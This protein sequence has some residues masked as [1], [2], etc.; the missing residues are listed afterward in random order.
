MEYIIG[1]DIGT[2]S[3]KAIAFDVAGKLLVE[4]QVGYPILTPQPD[5]CEQD[6]DV[7]FNA[8]LQGIRFITQKLNSKEYELLGV[9]FSS[10]MHSLIAMDKEGK[11]LTHSITWADTRSKN[12]AE[13]LRG[14]PLGHEI[15]MKTGTPIHPMSPLCK[16]AWLKKHQPDVFAGSERFISIKEYVLYRLFGQYVVDYSIASATGLFDIHRLDWCPQA[17]EVAGVTAKQL[18]A[19]VPPTHQ[20][21]GLPD[22]HAVVMGVDAQV[23]FIVGASDGCLANVGANAILPGNAAVTIGTSGAIRVMAQEPL[24]DSGERLF[25]YVLNSK[26]F[27]LGGAV[28]SGGIILRWFRDNFASQEMQQAMEQNADPYELLLK[29]AADIPA[30]A[31][32]LVF[33]PYLLG[34]R[35]PYWNAD[36]RGMFFGVDIRHTRNHFT[37]AV[38]EGIIYGL[39]SVG[40][41]LE[42]TAGPINVI[43]ANGGFA[44]SEQWVQML[45]DIFNKKVRVSESHETTA[46]GAAVVGLESLGILQSVEEVANFV[47]TIKEYIP[48]PEKQ[49]V[50]Q[51]RFATFE[52]LY[53]KLKDEF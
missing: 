17:L 21:K 27:I 20:L 47:P 34:E 32:G 12:I 36:A 40:K 9:S 30:G 49:A 29:K 5:F 14:T 28:N 25:S 23:P 33:L 16:L 4:N 19:L 24:S 13:A 48:D 37:R 38:M 45:A 50:Y 3:T 10:A 1:L 53:Q 51:Q 31:E 52:R 2:T 41:A 43:Y 11:A 35:A 15:Y 46:L 22:A 7:I 39:C 8:V 6:P 42:E 26:H 18:S 44:R